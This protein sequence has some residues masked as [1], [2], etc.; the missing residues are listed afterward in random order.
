MP[1]TDFLPQWKQ[2]L[3]VWWLPFVANQT[4]S[5]IQP[6]LRHW[7]QK[8]VMYY[9]SPDKSFDHWE[10]KLMKH[11]PSV[12]EE[13]KKMNVFAVQ[14]PHHECDW[15]TGTIIT[16]MKIIADNIDLTIIIIMIL[17]LYY[18]RACMWVCVIYNLNSI[19]ILH[20]S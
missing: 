2:F 16:D 14:N 11:M 9:G 8:M 6:L 17:R 1:I 15:E 18:I 5:S 10:L 4:V 20:N 3:L 19:P 7:D 13:N 12:W